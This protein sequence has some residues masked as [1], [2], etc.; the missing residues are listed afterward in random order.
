VQATSET[1]VRAVPIGLR[2][3]CDMVTMSPSP[4][5]EGAFGPDE[6]TAMS[7]ALNDICKELHIN[8]DSMARETIAIRIIE[9][10][11]RGERSPTKLRDR[12]LL[13]ANGGTR[14]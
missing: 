2:Q 14:R 1:Q 10:A 7:M 11:R 9:L 8:G 13:E 5:L 12:L 6:I 4:Q 3:G